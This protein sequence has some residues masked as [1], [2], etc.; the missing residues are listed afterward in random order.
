MFFT[1]HIDVMYE[2]SQSLNKN[3]KTLPQSVIFDGV[4]QE[5]CTYSAL[6]KAKWDYGQYQHESLSL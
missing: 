1:L 5:Y 3:Y 4:I 2:M 6:Q